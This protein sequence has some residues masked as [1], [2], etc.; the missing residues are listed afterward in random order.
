[1]GDGAKRVLAGVFG[2]FPYASF[3]SVD[4]GNFSCRR[5]LVPCRRLFRLRKGS[6]RPR[7][8][9]QVQP[10][11]FDAVL[12][13]GSMAGVNSHACIG[14]DVMM[15]FLAWGKAINSTPRHNHGASIHFWL[16]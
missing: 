6:V 14:R 8:D 3:R 12:R 16:T 1:V 5:Y 4:L 13:M 2:S 11:R 9:L 7:H 10:I 15:P